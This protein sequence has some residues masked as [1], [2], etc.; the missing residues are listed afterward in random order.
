M[1]LNH[2]VAALNSTLNSDQWEEFQ[3]EWSN[4]AQYEFGDRPDRGE[5]SGADFAVTFQKVRRN[6]KRRTIWNSQQSSLPPLN[7]VA[8]KASAGL[9]NITLPFGIVL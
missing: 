1:N 2:H 5:W 8:S 9:Q 6:L 4:L 3:Q 7:P